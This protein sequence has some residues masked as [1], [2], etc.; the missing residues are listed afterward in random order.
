MFKIRSH[1]NASGLKIVETKIIGNTTVV[2]PL[3]NHGNNK[4]SLKVCNNTETHSITIPLAS[5]M[6]NATTQ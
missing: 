5:D 3:F 1:E 2:R 6:L 4:S